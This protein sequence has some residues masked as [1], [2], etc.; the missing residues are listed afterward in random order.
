MGFV[1]RLG[2]DAVRIHALASPRPVEVHAKINC[3]GI[4]VDVGS[5]FGL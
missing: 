1:G 3:P 4:K 5:R 2:I